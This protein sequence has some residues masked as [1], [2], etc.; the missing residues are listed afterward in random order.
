MTSDELDRILSAEDRIVPS[1]GFAA[2]VMDTVRRE[3]ATPPPIPFPWTRALPGL[4]VGIA[5]L[6]GLLVAGF[7]LLRPAI[8]AVNPDTFSLA[9]L[10]AATR[11]AAQKADGAGWIALTL[12][13]TLAS[14]YF[15]FRATGSRN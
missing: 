4:V 7:A 13:L 5:A 9:Q 15:S 3:A 6:A 11:V 8:A 1:S 12:L 2:S 14:V 10:L